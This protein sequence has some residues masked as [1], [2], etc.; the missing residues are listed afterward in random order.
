MLV[1]DPSFEMLDRY[2]ALAGGK[3]VRVPWA[4]GPFPTAARIERLDERTGVIAIVSP[5][6]PTG[7]VAAIAG[8]VA[9]DLLAQAEHD[10]AR[11]RSW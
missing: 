8:M 9:A 4:A 3:L 7:E 5:N 2:A 6:N 10:P 1:P 11:Y